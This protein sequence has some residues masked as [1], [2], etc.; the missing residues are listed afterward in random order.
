MSERLAEHLDQA[1]TAHLAARRAAG[2]G[3]APL[4]A[5][6]GLSPA[7]S[8]AGVDIDAMLRVAALIDASTVPPLSASQR[9]RINARVLTGIHAA[10]A[11]PWWWRLLH[12]ETTRRFALAAGGALGLLVLATGAGGVAA[13]QRAL[14][15]DALYGTKLAVERVELSVRR[16]DDV[17]RAL[18]ASNRRL[19]ELTR[20]AA[21]RRW[22][23]VDGAVARYEEAVGKLAAARAE[24]PE[25]RQPAIKAELA[26]Q[27]LQVANLRDTMRDGERRMAGV[28]DLFISGAENPQAKS[29]P[30]LGVISTETSTTS[31]GAGANAVPAPATQV[32]AAAEPDP[33][34]VRRTNE[35]RG[36]V[37]AAFSDLQQAIDT[38]VEAKALDPA[39][40]GELRLVFESAQVLGLGRETAVVARTVSRLGA[41]LDSC[42]EQGCVSQEQIDAI[43][44]LLS[45]GAD[46]LGIRPPQPPQARIRSAPPVET[47]TSTP[48]SQ[49]SAV[50]ATSPASSG[51]GPAAGGA[52]VAPIAPDVPAVA[53]AIAVPATSVAA[54]APPIT[55]AGG[56]APNSVSAS[57]V[58]TSLPSTV[59]TPARPAGTSTPGPVAAGAPAPPTSN[60]AAA[61]AATPAAATAA[62]TR[63]SVSGPASS[64]AAPAID[65]G[66]T[67]TVTAAAA[68][69]PPRPAPVRT[70]TA[71]PAVPAAAAPPPAQPV[72]TAVAAAPPSTAN[73]TATATVGFAAPGTL[74][75]AIVTPRATA[76]PTATATATASP[77]ATA[78]ATA[79]P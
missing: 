40:A 47:A 37:S 12:P 18:R 24:A 25:E 21:E 22:S 1:I 41:A 67:P 70:P 10:R 64:A 51:G 17:D 23:D 56:S 62:G 28:V 8:E 26:R 65:T 63:E 15:G 68:P 57:P 46:A 39:V 42:A 76:T 36:R 69:M 13:A 66:D 30:R 55:P 71:P 79:R 19:D 38:G 48:N 58:A 43:H 34:A 52:P 6:R 20:L 2:D 11:H 4:P 60:A 32:Q 73:A 49:P 61:T 59:V 75:A 54:A 5:L 50:A 35:R 44:A 77:T 9:A 45:R 72:A 14:P 3:G 29:Q 74:P 53:T 27:F 33:A 31:A 78:T 7:S 16:D